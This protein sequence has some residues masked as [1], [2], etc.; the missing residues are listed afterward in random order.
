[1]SPQTIV[2][3]VLAALSR[4]ARAREPAAAIAEKQTQAASLRARYQL[5]APKGRFLKIRIDTSTAGVEQDGDIDFWVSMSPSR[6]GRALVNLTLLRKFK[7]QINSSHPAAR[8][9]IR[10]AVSTVDKSR[11]NIQN[12][13]TLKA[14]ISA[15]SPVQGILD[16]PLS[17]RHA[18]GRA[19]RGANL[20]AK[21]WT[22]VR[23]QAP[24]QSTELKVTA[25]IHQGGRYSEAK[26]LLSDAVFKRNPSLGRI[27]KALE[28]QMGKG[29]AEPYDRVKHYG[30]T[31]TAADRNYF[32]A[33]AASMGLSDWVVDHRPPLVQ[34][35]YVLDARYGKPGYEM[36]P[37]DRRTSAS[38]RRRMAPQDRS[39]SDVQGGTMSAQSLL[40]RK[41]FFGY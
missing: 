33:Q 24:S 3:R 27:Q 4:P 34:R 35:Y 30:H 17:M 14:R 40:W 23:G 16:K 41:K 29:P 12:W 8:A 7:N 15:M 38:D 11:S 2:S 25:L 39:Q 6:A 10:S 37:T 36:S 5:R 13:A 21:A 18:F 32:A 19:M 9:D 20:V 26:Q 31:P 28:F 1:M 22:A